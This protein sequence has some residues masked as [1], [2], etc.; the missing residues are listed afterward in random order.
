[1][2]FLIFI[3]DLP[4][5]FEYCNSNIYA[6]DVTVHDEDKDVETIENH[7]VCDF[8]NADDWRKPNK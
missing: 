5:S 6:D 1:M 7:L 8:G 3:N 2:L 4:L